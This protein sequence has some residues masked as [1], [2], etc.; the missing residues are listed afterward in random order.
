MVS[1][2]D[3]NNNSNNSDNNGNNDS[4]QKRAVISS[5]LLVARNILS[6][7]MSAPHA[8][9]Q[10]QQFQTTDVNQCLH[11]KSSGHGVPDV[12]LFDF[13]FLLVDYGKG[14]VFSGE[15]SPAKLKCSCYKERIQSS[16]IIG[17][18]CSRFITFT[19]DLCDQFSFVCD[20]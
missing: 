2:N 19:F 14:F 1:N 15:Q 7:G 4:L 12:N 10:Q 17:L 5:L 6:G 20:L 3:N 9:Q 16:K 18:I 8:H 13:I 11:N